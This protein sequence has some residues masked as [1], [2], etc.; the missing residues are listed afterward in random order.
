MKLSLKKILNES[1]DPKEGFKLGQRFAQIDI[2]YDLLSK[3]IESYRASDEDYGALLELQTE[4][5]NIRE[6]IRIHWN[7]PGFKEFYEA[8]KR[9]ADQ[10]NS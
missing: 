2:E 7:K 6:T 3:K 4:Q 5:N 10:T 9:G 8:F 1:L